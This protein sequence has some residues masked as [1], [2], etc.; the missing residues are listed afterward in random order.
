MLNSWVEQ[1]FVFSFLWHAD[2]ESKF[3]ELHI[4]QSQNDVSSKTALFGA[5]ITN[6]IIC[7]MSLL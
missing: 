5:Q 7:C 2:K 1:I 3:I 6:N 4:L